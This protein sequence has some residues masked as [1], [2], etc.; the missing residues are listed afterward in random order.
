[1]AAPTGDG[2]A[3]VVVCSEEFLLKHHLEV[4][5]TS[6]YNAKYCIIEVLLLYLDILFSREKLLKSC[7]NICARIC[8]IP[9]KV[10]VSLGCVDIP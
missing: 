3:A 2:G 4:L 5:A 7:L 6:I 8:Q 9:S 1:M 10:K